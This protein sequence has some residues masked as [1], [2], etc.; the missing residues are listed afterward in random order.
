MLLSKAL[1]AFC[2]KVHMRTLAQHLAG[3]ADGIRNVFHA[4]DSA[5]TKRVSVHDERIKLN[6]A[7]AIQETATAGIKGFIVFH[8]DDSLFDCV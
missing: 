8:D 1:G 3:G 4:A 7:L 2:D 6:L 5:G